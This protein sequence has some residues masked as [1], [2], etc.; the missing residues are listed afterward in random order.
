LQTTSDMASP[1]PLTTEIYSSLAFHIVQWCIFYSCFS[2]VIVVVYSFICF[3][4]KHPFEQCTKELITTL[5]FYVAL[6]SSTQVFNQGT[7]LFYRYSATSPCEAQVP[8]VLC[9]PR[10]LGSS[11]VP[12]FVVLHISLTIQRVLST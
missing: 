3:H 6:Y 7:L 8:R 10:M 2:S 9:V 5:Y 1:C 12:S 11:I 4:Y